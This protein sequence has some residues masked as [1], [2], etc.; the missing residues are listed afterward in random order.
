MSPRGR[1]R[2]FDRDRA[3]QVAMELFWAH[4]YEGVS[5]SDLTAAI[6]ISPP[7]LYSAFGSKEE[8]FRES[9]DRYSSPER[10]PIGQ[11]IREQPTARAMI[12][13]MLR[14]S[15]DSVTDPKTPRGCLV[16]LGAT[17]CTNDAVRDFLCRRRRADVD[18]VRQRLD[19]AV[20]EGDLPASA[21][22]AGI[23][24]FY[25]TVQAGLSIQARDGRSREDLRAVV[26]RAMLAWDA[27]L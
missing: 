24:T 4:G 2:S 8:L 21:D 27:M 19:R 20:A 5:M 9:V 6:G 16:V 22:T 25:M 13:A 7:S 3:L 15:A 17:N 10:A 11:A 14:K 18:A 1:P 26:D 23:A 12:E